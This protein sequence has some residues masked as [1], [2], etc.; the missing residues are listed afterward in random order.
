MR[1]F[2]ISKKSMFMVLAVIAVLALGIWGYARVT[3]G[4]SNGISQPAS[5]DALYTLN[6]LPEVKDNSLLEV[7]Y[8]EALQ[9]WEKAGINDVADTETV[10]VDAVGTTAH[11]EQSALST[12]TFDQRA[13]VLSWRNVGEGWI[14]Y[15][16]DVPFAGLYQMDLTYHPVM[17]EGGRPAVIGMQI[18][19]AYPFREAR[20]M[21]LKREWRD[22]LPL[23]LD[24]N[25]DHIRPK[26]QDVSG[27]MTQ[28][29]KDSTG[30]YAA[31]LKWYLTAG[32]HTIRIN[33]SDAMYI[34]TLQVKA[35]DAPKPYSEIDGQGPSGTSAE[36]IV[37]EAEQMSAKTVSSIQM[38]SDPDPLSSPKAGRHLLFNFVMTYHNSDAV[39]WK[40][41]VPESGRYKL[42]LRSK[43]DR[44]INKASFR[45][46]YI[47]GRIPFSEMYAYKFPY[48][49]GWN[50]TPI[51]NDQGVPFEFALEKGEHTI[52]L[53]TTHAPLQPYIIVLNKLSATLKTIDADLKRLT[54]DQV[55][56]NRTWFI[57]RDMPDL[58]ERLRM[59]TEQLKQLRVEM[60]QINGGDESVRG[61]DG[62]IRDLEALLKYPDEIPNKASSVTVVM[63]HLA[64]LPKSFIFQ[65]LELDRIY[66]AP[67]T[68]ELPRMQA[69]FIE[70]TSAALGN[71]FGSFSKKTTLS[72]DKDV[73]NV[74]MYRG[75]DYVNLLQQMSDQ[76]F[77]PQ[78]GIKVKINL[79]S[80]PTV[81]MMSNAAGN[82]PDAAIG[83]PQNTPYEMAL[84]HS[85]ADL[86]KFKGFDKTMADFNPGTLLP[87][88]YSGGYY[89]IPETQSFN[90]L[91]YRK[92][93]LDR[94]G[95]KVPQTWNDVIAMLPTLQQNKMNF[96]VSSNDMI[97]YFYQNG[98]E[99][100]SPDGHKTA[101]D[102]P[103]AFKGF[104][105]W[106]DL[107]NTYGM[108]MSVSSFYQHFRDG[109]MPIGV[110]DFNTYIQIKSAAPEL[111]GWWGTAPI[112]GTKQADGTIARWS[113]G[114][115]AVP[116]TASLIS[117]NSQKK[118]QAWEFL[119][120]Y[121]SGEV[122]DQFG[123]QMESFYGP[124]YRWNSANVDAF[125]RL[126]WEKDDLKAIL[127]TWAWIKEVPNV[128]GGYLLNRELNNAWNRTV[129]DGMNYRVSLEQ[130][131]KEINRELTR[132][133]REFT[134]VDPDR[135]RSGANLPLID[136]P[137]EGVN[138]YASK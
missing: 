50:A 19:G 132:K 74:W 71:F 94:L 10:D 69:D 24:D 86:S 111:D 40:V 45:T 85:A 64:T 105:Q 76:L 73:L 28:P 78:S 4:D 2:G 62:S 39:S 52:T 81:L 114:S 59:V 56:T 30:S 49:K 11:S 58:P 48:A 125:A 54:A 126:P 103:E 84:R 72:S 21:E 57:E 6:L 53:E 89:G 119:Q 14:E 134:R 82:P 22:E 60:E 33:S 70:R 115:A 121:M 109:D 65:P 129:V 18:D 93:I 20:S 133:D 116:S 131:I 128:P 63:E 90:V 31:P 107:F 95:L 67:V 42:V 34:A 44:I 12:E 77:T 108:D 32:K 61:L 113:A 8:A 7:Y 15:V 36:T 135:Y 41:Q 122:Q 98:A 102:T 66:V 97:Q 127:E 92:D 87:M 16:I 104:K 27:W 124:A 46:L 75:R 17:G 1:K 5:L 138:K 9:A 68:A 106:T 118:D 79:I 35:P 83:V 3:A 29:L 43:Q 101:L 130:S 25:G 117:E 110:A 99:F 55:D 23:K 51:Q 123:Q 120:W 88:Y 100:F 96:F 37:L 137:W 38:D 136:H 112:P 47:D 26:Q 80:D 13:N 91:F